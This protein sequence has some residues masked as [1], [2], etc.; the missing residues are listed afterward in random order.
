MLISY[1]AVVKPTGCD[2][3]LRVF[4]GL[5]AEVAQLVEPLLPKQDVASSNLVFRSNSQLVQKL[6]QHIG[7]SLE[8]FF[9]FDACSAQSM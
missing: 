6:T 1:S 7:D 5:D 9:Y 2:T 4:L 3:Q 8:I